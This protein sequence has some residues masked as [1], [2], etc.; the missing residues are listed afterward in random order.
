MR[1]FLLSFVAM[2]GLGGCYAETTGG[3]YVGEP[4]V[5]VGVGYVEPEMVVVSPGVSVV[6]DYDYPVFYSGGLYWRED[7][8]IWYSSRYHNS[9][10][11]VN[12]SVPYAVGHIENRG[13]YSHYRPAGYVS[14]RRA[15]A[16]VERREERRVERRHR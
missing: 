12:R 9:G 14:Q 2:A 6:Y 7:G 11:V 10:W 8:G 5:G 16:R 1:N 4:V 3:V 15:P 13:A